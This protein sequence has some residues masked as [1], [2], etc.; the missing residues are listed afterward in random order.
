MAIFGNIVAALSELLLALSAVSLVSRLPAMQA[1]VIL[2]AL[3]GVLT[4]SVASRRRQA[5]APHSSA[6]RPAFR[7]LSALAS[8][9]LHTLTACPVVAGVAVA[10]AGEALASQP[11]RHP[12]QTAG[13]RPVQV[14]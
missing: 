5:G 10:D 6:P 14:P 9:V 3:A 13:M 7:P 12:G 1:P 8:A 4:H 2:L 11:I